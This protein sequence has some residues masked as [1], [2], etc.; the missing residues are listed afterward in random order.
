[1]KLLIVSATPF[2]IAPLLSHCE[3]H[4]T[5]KEKN[6][7]AQRSMS[8]NVLIT[9]VGMPLTAYALG[10]ELGNRTYDLVIQ[11]GVGGAFNKEVPLGTVFNVVSERF[12]DLGA[13][14]ANGSLSDVFELELTDPNS[15]PFRNGRLWNDGADNYDFLPKAHG[16]TVNKVHGSAGS[17]EAIRT[18]YPAD[19]ESMEGAAFFYACLNAGLPF[20]EIRATSNHVEPRQRNHWKLEQAIQGL[21][22]TLI[23]MLEMLNSNT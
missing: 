12:G 9:G 14:E 18:K 19:M 13:E 7:F 3:A 4:F 16:L 20:L 1:M 22:T 5:K 17:I 11:A 10:R 6:A 8:V 21:N 2:E 15:W 23:E